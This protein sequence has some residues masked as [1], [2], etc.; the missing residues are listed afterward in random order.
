MIHIESS[1]NQCSETFKANF[2]SNGATTSL[3]N[4][5]FHFVHKF[6]ERPNLDL[7][8]MLRFRIRHLWLANMNYEQTQFR[9]R[10]HNST[11]DRVWFCSIGPRTLLVTHWF[12]LQWYGFWW[13]STAF[14]H[15][16]LLW[17][18]DSTSAVRFS[19]EHQSM[20]WFLKFLEKK[21]T[22]YQMLYHNRLLFCAKF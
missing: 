8:S 6:R 20:C 19:A 18:Y 14:D 4:I 1:K 13:L 5:K 3:Q 21:I 7:V 16:S 12:H 10:T 9:S 11:N 17:Y 22:N 2:S 15:L